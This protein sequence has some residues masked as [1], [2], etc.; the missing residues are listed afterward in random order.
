MRYVSE[1]RK[2][3]RTKAPIFPSSMTISDMRLLLGLERRLRQRDE[4][5][6]DLRLLLGAADHVDAPRGEG[7]HRLAQRRCGREGQEEMVLVPV[8]RG[9]DLA[10]GSNGRV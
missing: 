3:R 1:V 8:F 7:V 4:R 6:L 5:L 2:S 9:E 10:C